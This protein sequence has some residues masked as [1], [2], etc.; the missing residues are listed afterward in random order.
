MFEP[1]DKELFS[2]QFQINQALAFAKQY[3]NSVHCK[4]CG[5]R[6]FNRPDSGKINCWVCG[7]ELDWDQLFEEKKQREKL[8]N[9]NERQKEKQQKGIGRIVKWIKKVL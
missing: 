6:Y 1:T 2:N 5:E 8:I 7:N 3:E 4:M 9:K